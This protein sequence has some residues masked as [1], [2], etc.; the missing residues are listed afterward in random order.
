MIFLVF[1]ILMLSIWKKGNYRQERAVQLATFSYTPGTKSVK[2]GGNNYSLN[3][4]KTTSLTTQI[5][6]KKRIVK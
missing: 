6:K 5:H 1:V 4:S 2:P 3:P